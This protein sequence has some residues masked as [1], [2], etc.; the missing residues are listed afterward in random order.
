MIL[1]VLPGFSAAA[2][3]DVERPGAELTGVVLETGSEDLA[4]AVAGHAPHLVAVVVPGA[5]RD[6][7]VLADL[8]LAVQVA[9]V[10]VVNLG[11]AALDGALQAGGDA[12]AADDTAESTR[13]VLVRLLAS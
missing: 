8:L 6:D 9:E 4:H 7:C 11:V 5:E 2:A 3:Q 1:V 10:A 13:S 12:P